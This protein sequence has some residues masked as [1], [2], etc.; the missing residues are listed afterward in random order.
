MTPRNADKALILVEGP[1]D[2]QV[3]RHY[4]DSSYSFIRQCEGCDVVRGVCE[5]VRKYKPAIKCLGIL[6]SD[7]RRLCG[8]NLRR[9]NIVYTDTHDMETMILFSPV[10]FT[11]LCRIAACSGPVHDVIVEDLRLLSFMRWYNMAA[12]LSYIDYELDIEN[13][14]SSQMRDYHYLNDRFIPTDGSPKPWLKRCFDRFAHEKKDSP[15]KQVINGHDYLAR[16][17]HYARTIDGKQFSSNELTE[18]LSVVSDLAWFQTTDLCRQIIEW[19]RSN[20]IRVLA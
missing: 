10:C 2:E 8:R 5:Y 17:C 11:K 14:T 3:Y 7:F 13:A 15:M 16:F 19:E 12:R 20:G 18:F 4:F 1:D 6:D 9:P